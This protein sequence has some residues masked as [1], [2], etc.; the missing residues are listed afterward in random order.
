MGKNPFF[1]TKSQS[2]K[3]SESSHEAL[4]FIFA[5]IMFLT[6]IKS[7]YLLVKNF[8]KSITI[9]L[10]NCPSK[11]KLIKKP[12]FFAPAHSHSVRLETLFQSSI[13]SFRRGGE[14]SP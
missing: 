13:F 9:W 14:K 7:N 4:T 8:I 1:G 6:L 10:V 3:E 2:E 11:R 12:G 5:L